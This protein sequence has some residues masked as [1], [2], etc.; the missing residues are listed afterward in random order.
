[1]DPVVHFEIPAEDIK[2]MSKFYS[3]AFGWKTKDLGEEMGNYVLASTTDE[4]DET[5]R[6]LKR[7]IINGGFFPK[8]KDLDAHPSLNITVDD[9][10]TAMKKVKNAGG[11]IDSE[12]Q[13]VPG[14]GTYVTFLDTEGNRNS[15]ME[16]TMEM[17][18]KGKFN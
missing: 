6:P 14:F 18:A 7:S 10:E 11:K 13:D 3:E 17:K 2:R 9:L 15:I 16:P 12:P 4:V 1:M 8:G 5:G